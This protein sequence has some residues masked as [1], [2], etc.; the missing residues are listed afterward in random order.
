[1]KTISL[2]IDNPIFE[3]TESILSF[4]HI[5]RNRYINQALMHYNKLQK[6]HQLEK[7]LSA[8]SKACKTSSMEV[9]KEFENIDNYDF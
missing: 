5:S 1:M 2:K 4:M 6:R 3:D 8:E 7:L 9:L